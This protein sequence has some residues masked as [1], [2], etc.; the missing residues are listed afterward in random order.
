MNTKIVN[1][2]TNHGRMSGRDICIDLGVDPVDVELACQDGTIQR[3]APEPGGVEPWY[4][5]KLRDGPGIDR[6]E[7]AYMIAEYDTGEPFTD[8][9]DVYEVADIV[10]PQ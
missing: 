4:R 5:T 7:Q 10:E 3:C 6:D 8:I 2:L 1:Y 9:C